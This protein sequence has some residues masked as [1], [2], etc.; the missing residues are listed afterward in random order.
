MLLLS[1]TRASPL[2]HV[3]SFHF[4]LSLPSPCPY[5]LAAAVSA[6]S[7]LCSVLLACLGVSAVA[8][9]LSS[10]AGGSKFYHRLFPF[11]FLSL[12]FCFFECVVVCSAC[13]LPGGPPLLRVQVKCEAC[14]FCGQCK[15]N[16]IDSL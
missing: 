15:C 9:I 4:L 12:C 3:P 6:L 7:V 5:S 2:S 13:A 1:E 14:S 16:T 11:Y 10:S 8:V